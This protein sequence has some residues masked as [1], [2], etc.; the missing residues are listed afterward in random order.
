MHR[1]TFSMA[2]TLAIAAAVAP[3]TAQDMLPGQILRWQDPGLVAEGEA[4]YEAECAACHGAN[5][6]GQPDWQV[7]LVNGR[8]PAPPHD[9]TGHTWHHPDELLVA[10]TALGTAA[11]IGGDYESDMIGF[12]DRLSEAE[13]VA[14][15][16][17]IKS[18]WPGDVIEIHNEVNA[19][20]AQQDGQ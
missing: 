17:Y 1:R 20:A 10:I 14:V 19:R 11:L 12:S 2:S 9:R 3:A 16:S 8:L 13:I 18:T 15:L 6:E 4:I 7:R 5:L